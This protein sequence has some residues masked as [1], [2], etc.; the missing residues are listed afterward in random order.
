MKAAIYSILSILWVGLCGGCM[1]KGP[2][3]VV[4]AEQKM[5]EHCTYI[6][7]ITH[8]SNM[9][10][11]QIHPKFADNGRHEVLCRAEGLNATHVV[12]LAE[13]PSGAAALAYRCGD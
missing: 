1:V 9:G 11:F 6:D 8:I 4:A 12:W 5:V 7:T 13:H 10:A 3:A 2:P